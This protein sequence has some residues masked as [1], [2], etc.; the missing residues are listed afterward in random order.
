MKAE[1]AATR[2]ARWFNRRIS[3]PLFSLPTS[4]GSSECGRELHDHP[5]AFAAEARLAAGLPRLGQPRREVTVDVDAAA[6]GLHQVHDHEVLEATGLRFVDRIR[7][8]VVFRHELTGAHPG[9]A[10]AGHE[11]RR[12]VSA[13]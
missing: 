13:R 1:T 5:R 3:G 9:L 6:L 11:I 2:P 8:A 12:R 7:P 4:R 10:I